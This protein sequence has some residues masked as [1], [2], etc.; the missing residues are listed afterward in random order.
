MS[1]NAPVVAHLDGGG[2]YESDPAATAFALEEV[3]QQRRSNGGH[4]LNEAIV[5]DQTWELIVQMD[6][7]MLC[8]EGF[9]DGYYCPTPRKGIFQ[10]DSARSRWTE[11]WANS[12]TISFTLIISDPLRTS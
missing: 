9:E 7:D 6:H 5:T 12:W 1:A 3:E 4:Q 10:N 2:I 8:V 11:A